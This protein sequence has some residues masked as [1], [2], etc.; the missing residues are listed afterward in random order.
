LDRAAEGRTTIVIAHRL[1]T[2]R[3]ADSIVVMAQGKIVEQGTHDELLDKRGAYYNLVEAQSIAAQNIKDA[4]A[5]ES[6][7][8]TPVMDE[9]ARSDDSDLR[10]EKLTRVATSK[11][12]QS[13]SSLALKKRAKDE[14]K[15]YSLWTLLKL[16]WSYNRKEWYLMLAGLFFSIIA[17]G[18][19]P[20][21]AIFFAKALTAL[22]LPPSRYAELT[23]GMYSILQAIVSRDSNW[24][25]TWTSGHR[26]MSCSPLCS[27][28]QMPLM[29]S[30]SVT[31]RNG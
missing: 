24:R 8:Q 15:E 26:C 30:C 3:N 5:E 25:Q 13:L 23:K 31:A 20:V 12:Q 28:S 9:G 29:A 2:I 18:G 17:G 10:N 19:N 22:S 27:C 7:R 11:S 1:S 6:G 21:Q 4:E 14:E 16:V